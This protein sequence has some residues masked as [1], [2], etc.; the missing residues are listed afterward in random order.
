M[1]HTHAASIADFLLKLYSSA[2]E[3]S[4]AAFPEFAIEELKRFV[5]FDMALFGLI[6]PTPEVPSG[7]DCSWTHIHREPANMMEEWLSLCSGDYVLQ[8]ML[9]D[10]G[11]VRSYHVPTVFSKTEDAKILDFALRT[12]HI[13]LAAVANRYGPDGLSGAFS[14]RRADNTWRFSIAENSLV[15]LLSPHVWEAIRINRTI[16]DGKVQGLGLEPVRGLCV[17]DDKG[18][19]IF[20][21]S[22]FERLRNIMY[23]D[24]KTYRLPD[25]L[26]NSLL[27]EERQSF[28]DGRMLFA[29]K[30][31]A[32]LRFITATLTSGLHK[33]SVREKEVANFFGTGLTHAEIADELRI[34]SSTVRRHIEAVY[35]KLEI[36]NKSDLSFL[37]HTSQDKSVEHVLS[38]LEASVL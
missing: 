27:K 14:I 2:R 34:S 25:I 16:M 11:R 7:V 6:R 31:V 17:A 36:R 21:D 35:K 9:T 30:K 26:K 18:T 22:S 3:M 5:D 12:R 24:T 8:N 23:R 28:E 13:N 19:I 32:N 38:A 1:S 4:V 29:C 15:E 20:Q 10:L 37:I 33:L